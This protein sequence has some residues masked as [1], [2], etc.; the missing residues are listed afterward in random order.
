MK[1]DLKDILNAKKLLADVI[2]PTP[3]RYSNS[4]SEVLQKRIFFKYENYQR[5]G[6]FKLRGAY[7][8]ISALSDE[9]KRLGVVASSA[10][11]HA[12]GVALSA[13]LNGIRATVVMP[14]TAPLNKVAATKGYGAQVIQVGHLVDD[15]YLYAKKLQAE[16]NMT[17]IHPY[18]D[19]L[20]IAGQGTVGL[21]IL[22]QLK[23]VTQIVVPIGGGGLISGI[24]IAAKAINPQV[25]IIGI[26]SDK[27]ASMASMFN[28]TEYIQPEPRV[29]T[30]AD[31]IAVKRPS[32]VMYDSFI[33]HLVDEIHTVSD[34]EVAEAIVFL[35]ERTKSVVEGA[36]AVGLA[37]ALNGK[38]KLT[39]DTV[40][41]LTGGNIDLNM[42]E[43]IIEKG[44]MKSGRLVEISVIVDD[45]PG[46][47]N[48][49]TEILAQK[50]ANI[51]SVHHDRHAYGL[52]IRQTRVDFVIETMD[53][54]H[55]NQIKD[56]L[57]QVGI[58]LLV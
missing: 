25:R 56:A 6:S 42:I 33:G 14:V 10:G 44:Q 2:K 47:L 3:L 21:E 52:A 37:A 22:E 20:V 39:D 45:T 46:M 49:L 19:P 40:F 54:Q 23:S 36:G 31:G 35:L 41:V 48:K 58:K 28:G 9:E 43:K 57:I 18:E 50:K 27:V 24:A 13:K 51:I 15:A 38:I 17:L 32:Q 29:T 4:A 12:Q 11:N 55:I 53:F 5:T 7:N 30:I 16:L 1:V 26:Q 8:R 34:E